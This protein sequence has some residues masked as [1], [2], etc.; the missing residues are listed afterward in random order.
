MAFNMRRSLT[1]MMSVITEHSLTSAS[2][3]TAWIR[4]T[5][6]TISRVNCLRVQ[7]RS[8]SSLVFWRHDFLD[9]TLNARVP[10]AR[11]A[12]SIDENRQIFVPELWDDSEESPEAK[13]S[14]RIKQVWFPGV[15]EDVGGGFPETELSD[16]ALEWMIKEATA[17]EHPLIAAL[18]APLDG[19]VRQLDIVA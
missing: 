2:S 1:S 6:C 5:C 17:V 3:R 7:V 4:C 13:A 8:R 12:L 14:G 10:Y 19:G 18:Q 11:Q 15:H 16:L 9:A